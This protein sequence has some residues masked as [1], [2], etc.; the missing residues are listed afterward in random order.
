MSKMVD[1]QVQ[2]NQDLITGVRRNLSYLKKFG[3]K[4]EA[5]NDLESK[6]KELKALSLE[7][8]A[9]TEQARAKRAVLNKAM[10][11]AKDWYNDLKAPIKN[12][13]PNTH[14][15]QYGIPDKK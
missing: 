15:L 1:T 3:Y 4:E 5:L 2:K 13:L 8:D 11:V 14:W 6:T 7:I 9:L 10:A 12:N